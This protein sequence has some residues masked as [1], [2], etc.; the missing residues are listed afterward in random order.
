MFEVQRSIA[1]LSTGLANHQQLQKKAIADE[2]GLEEHM[3]Q[4]H[5]RRYGA[6][7]F[8]HGKKRG[9][10]V[11]ETEEEDEGEGNIAENQDLHM[12]SEEE[13]EDD[14]LGTEEFKIES[15]A[16]QNYKIYQDSPG[17]QKLKLEN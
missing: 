17:L 4:S 8:S 2:L 15:P 5:D 10:I 16:R 1:H 14:C 12:A 11:K 13:E 3:P 6:A 9:D 7:G